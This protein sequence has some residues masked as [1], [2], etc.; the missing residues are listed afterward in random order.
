MHMCRRSQSVLTG[1]DTGC[2]LTES[3]CP[4]FISAVV[5]KYP[6]EKQLRG[7]RGLS[8]LQLQGTSRYFREV[9]AVDIPS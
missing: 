6:D 4:V 9:E 7:E 5:V 2:P 3:T 8:G 1:C